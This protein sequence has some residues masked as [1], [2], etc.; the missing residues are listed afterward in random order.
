MD[1][2]DAEAALNYCLIEA[3][4]VRKRLELEMTRW[5]SILKYDISAY[6]LVMEQ[7]TLVPFDLEVGVD[8]WSLFESK[9]YLLTSWLVQQEKWQAQCIINRLSGPGKYIA[10]SFSRCSSLKPDEFTNAPKKTKWTHD[11]ATVEGRGYKQ[12]MR[13]D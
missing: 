5:H 11:F 9:S 12:F 7:I 1:V 10:T 13:C 8:N 2:Y 4:L 3:Q 6:W